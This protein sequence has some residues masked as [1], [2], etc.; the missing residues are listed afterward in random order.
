MNTDPLTKNNNRIRILRG[1]SETKREILDLKFDF[2]H[3]IQCGTPLH[4][5]NPNLCFLEWFI[6]FFEAEGCF[7]K[8]PSTSNNQK[9][10]FGI[11]ITQKDP[12][13][14]YKIR[15]NLGFGRVMQSP[16][17]I[18]LEDTDWRYYIHDFKNLQRMIVLLNG[19]LVTE[20]KNQDFKQWLQ[21]INQVKNTSYC[22]L[23]RFPQVSFQTGWLSGFLEGDGRFWVSDKNVLSIKNQSKSLQFNINLKFYMT[24]K[25]ERKLLKQIGTLFKPNL[26]V[27]T[28]PNPG[29]D[30][31]SYTIETS[32]LENLLALSSYLN[33]YP[34]LGKYRSITLKRWQRLINYQIYD[35]PT[36]KKSIKKLKRLIKATN[37]E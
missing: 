32:H 13:L 27:Y 19:N 10:S 33:K 12:Q 14:L 2:T 36:T 17:S 22:Q 28:F 35:Y 20:K 16:Q 24:Q 29:T 15:T 34:F 25:G 30:S 26:E 7:L 21:L 9:Q 1:S 18:N 5:P 31:L 6:G 8:W 11:E 37:N 4:K 3:Y 23:I